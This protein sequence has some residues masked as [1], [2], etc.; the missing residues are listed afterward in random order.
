MCSVTDVSIFICD[1]TDYCV[2]IVHFRQIT[3]FV[4][5]EIGLIPPKMKM[6]GPF[7]FLE[8]PF[9]F[10]PSVTVCNNY[11]PFLNKFTHF[12]LLKF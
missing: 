12:A 5:K 7:L 3:T 6:E 8:G 2:K 9:P 11:A 10:L 1:R 4:G